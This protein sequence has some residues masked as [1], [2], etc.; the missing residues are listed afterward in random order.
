MQSLKLEPVVF[1]HVA[2][3]FIFEMVLYSVILL[4]TQQHE[5]LQMCLL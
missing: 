1:G 3:F 2:V 4:Q 5:V